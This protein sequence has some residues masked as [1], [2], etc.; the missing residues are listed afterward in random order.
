[1]VFFFY[2][3]IFP[4]KFI[5]IWKFKK[6]KKKF[7]KIGCYCPLNAVQSPKHFTGIEA[8]AW[9]SNLDLGYCILGTL[10]AFVW[11]TYIQ[12]SYSAENSTFLFHFCHISLLHCFLTFRYLAALEFCHYTVLFH[13]CILELNY[14]TCTHCFRSKMYWHICMF[15]NW[16][17]NDLKI[18]LLFL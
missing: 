14:V 5:F 13:H 8:W 10:H 12:N 7:K 15:V 11:N 3:E 6:L 1:M 9:M 2:L 16:C 17:K 4:Q 18:I